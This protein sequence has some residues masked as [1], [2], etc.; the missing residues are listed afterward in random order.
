MLEQNARVR[1]VVAPPRDDLIPFVQFYSIELSRLADG[2]VSLGITATLSED[3]GDLTGIEVASERVD[4]LA[5][6]LAIIE[7]AVALPP[8]PLH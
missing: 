2:S 8:S 3:D 7:S 1:P 4:S 6:A 5:D